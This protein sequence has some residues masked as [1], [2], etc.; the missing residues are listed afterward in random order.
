MYPC[1]R[2]IHR[3]YSYAKKGNYVS[4]IDDY[5]RVIAMDPGNSH[6]FHNRG[7][8]YDK[9]GDFERAIQDFTKVLD[10]DSSNANAYF[11]CGST[12]DS[13]G[14]CK[15]NI[16]VRLRGRVLHIDPVVIWRERERERK[17]ACECVCTLCV[18]CVYTHTGLP[19]LNC[20]PSFLS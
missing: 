6:A 5:S 14:N 15:L 12:H 2:L 10:L 8:S 1:H 3:G 19:M 7:I 11:N 18:F 13:I 17:S 16:Y 4:A 9:N 20:A